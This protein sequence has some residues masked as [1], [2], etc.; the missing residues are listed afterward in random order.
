MRRRNAAPPGAITLGVVLC[1]ALACCAVLCFGET[2]ADT[3]RVPTFD[4]V[5]SAY[6]ENLTWLHEFEREFPHARLRVYAKHEEAALQWPG[7]RVLPNVGRCDHTYA[8]Y[9]VEHYDALPDQV[10][11]VTASANDLPHKRRWLDT[12][13]WTLRRGRASWHTCSPVVGNFHRLARRFSLDAYC[14]SDVHNIDV[15]IDDD[16]HIDAAFAGVAGA[17]CEIV[18]ADVRPMEAWW[19]RHVGVD[20]PFPRVWTRG[21]IFAARREALQQTP[22][23]VWRRLRDEL[24]VGDNLEAGHFMERAWLGLAL[25]RPS[26]RELACLAALELRDVAS[27]AHRAL[28]G[29]GCAAPRR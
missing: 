18:R 16:G 26:W 8:H 17:R 20:V 6:R 14:V 28:F 2:S 13:V 7:A 23:D 27:N 29:D 5:V 3:A 22:L 25:P 10:L 21:G 19:A 24:S 1:V 9:L 4:I 12:I 15:D 11:F